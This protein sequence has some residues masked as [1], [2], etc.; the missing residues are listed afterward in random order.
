MVKCS[1]QQDIVLSSSPQS[2]NTESEI[3]ENA[4]ELLLEPFSDLFS[5]IQFLTL[6]CFTVCVSTLLCTFSYIPHLCFYETLIF[7]LGNRLKSIKRDTVPA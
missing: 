4:R 5:L 6:I 3:S 7:N 1:M 2:P